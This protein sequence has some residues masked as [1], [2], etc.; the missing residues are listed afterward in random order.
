MTVHPEPSGSARDA[1][2]VVTLYRFAL[3]VLPVRFRAAYGQ[4]MVAVFADLARDACARGGSAGAVRALLNEVPGLLTLAAAEHRDGWAR[5]RAGRPTARASLSAP[6]PIHL[7]HPRRTATMI[8]SIAHDLRSAV[9]SIV[10]SPSVTLIAIVSLALGIGANTAIFSVLNGVLLKE[11]S[12]PDPTRL[13]AI[14]EG[15]AGQQSTVLN[16]TSPAS[17]L[18]WRAQARSFAAIAAYNFNQGIL[19]GRGEPEMLVGAGSFG[20]LFDVLGVR[21]AIGRTLTIADEDPTVEPA[22]VLSDAIWRRL[23]GADS[24]VVGTTL[25]LNGRPRRIVG[26]MPQSFRFP[27]GRAQFWTPQQLQPDFRANRDQYFLSTIARLKPGI[28]LDAARSDLEMVAGRLRADWPQYNTDLRLNILPFRTSLVTGSE[29][30]LYLLMGAVVL[31]L[32]IACANVGNL[33]LAK[34]T[35]R[36]REI[37]VR[38]ALGAGR[39]RIARQLLTECVLLGL[40]GG[41]AGLVL[42]NWMLGALLPGEAIGLPRVEEVGLDGR[43]FAFTFALSAVAGIVFGLVP[44]V[45]LTSGRATDALRSGGR[46]AGGDRW[47]RRSLVVGELVLAVTLLAGAGLL[48]RSFAQLQ[49]VSPGFSTAGVLTFDVAVRNPRPGFFDEAIERLRALP[50]VDGAALVSQIPATGRGIGAWVNILERPLPANQTPPAEA[51]RVISP[52]YFSTVGIPL[53]RG[54]F[55]TRDDRLDGQ[56]SVVINQALARRYWPDA[57]PI[58]KE[59]YL[60]APD[61]RLFPDARIVGVVGDTRDL[62][63]AAAP[64]PAVFI[65]ARMMPRWNSFSYVLRTTGDPAA[66][67]GPVRAEFR[68][69]DPTAPMRN[70]RTMEEVL[71]GSLAPAR[72]TMTLLSVF[73][74]VALVLACVGIFGVLSFTVA[75][76]TRE[77]GIRIALGAAPIAVQG[78]VLREA[79]AL[80]AAGVALGLVVTAFVTRFMGSMVYGIPRTDPITYGAV[81][82]LLIAVAALASLLPARRATKVSPLVALQSE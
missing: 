58:G 26:V 65:P 42:G 9:R 1:A 54:R 6:S 59:I 57:D 36:R 38:Q 5:R 52:E 45:R 18:D 75:Q 3:R 12:F 33:L 77:L 81:A 63:P 41:V 34:G 78:L 44:A 76:R 15:R 22:I 30:P 24:A 46:T 4:A 71:A 11:L 27:D 80:T 62:G 48:L 31:V 82:L 13:V 47:A 60:G 69:M 20:G 25:N 64:V 67:V 66:L 40:A 17:F 70:V 73:A 43:V 55:P 74:A 10:R 72:W 2:L 14:G 53:V 21:A 16:S 56:R 23:F 51:Y 19:V 35:A 32:L 49:A 37:A 79:M 50:G 29:R 61:N 28:A 39:G 7:P 8:D 68:T